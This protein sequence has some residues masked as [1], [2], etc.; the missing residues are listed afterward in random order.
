MTFVHP[1][2]LYLLLILIPLIVWYIVRL[3]K[4]QASFKLASTQAFEGMKKNLRVY[5][6]H[7]PFALR[8]IAIA[9]IIIVIAR[10]QSVSSWEETKTQGIDIVLALDVSGS[11]LAQDLKPNRL[12]AAKKVAAEFINTRKNDKIGLVILPEKVL[13]NVR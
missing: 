5:M 2:Y 6:R 9:L 4:M 10:P 8:M 11:M 7:L 3:S 13:R 12:E 1:K